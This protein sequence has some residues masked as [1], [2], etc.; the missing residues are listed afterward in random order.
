MIPRVL[1]ALVALVLAVA[2]AGILSA[3]AGPGP[4]GSPAHPYPP[5]MATPGKD[6]PR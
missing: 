2:A 5:V 6:G 3:T 4:D 1:A